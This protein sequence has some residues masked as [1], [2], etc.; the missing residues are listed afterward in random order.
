MDFRPFG[1][2]RLHFG[3]VGEGEE[4]FGGLEG[5]CEALGREAVVG[6]V[7]ETYSLAG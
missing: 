5:F 3:F 2:G 4:V 7:G 1:M 6:D